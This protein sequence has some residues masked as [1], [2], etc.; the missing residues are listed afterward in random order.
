MTGQC[1]YLCIIIP[2]VPA[3]LQ[4]HFSCSIVQFSSKFFPQ[5]YFILGWDTYFGWARGEK[6]RFGNNKSL[7]CLLKYIGT[8]IS[9]P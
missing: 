8:I 7:S 2:C 3:H 1:P 9:N 4:H 5:F 6:G